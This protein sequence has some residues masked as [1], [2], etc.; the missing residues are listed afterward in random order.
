MRIMCILSL[1]IVTLLTQAQQAKASGIRDLDILF[2]IDNS[3]S[4]EQTQAKVSNFAPT[5]EK[6]LTEKNYDVR[7]AVTTTDAFYGNQ[8]LNE[9][10]SLC[11]VQQTKFRN[12]FIVGTSG[13]G[14]E[15]AFSSLEA[16]LSSPLN[17]GFHRPGAFLSVVIISDGD[18]FSH[19]TIN[20]DEDYS[21][22]TLHPISKTID[23]LNG[24]THGLPKKDYSVSTI[25]VLDSNCR[26]QLKT[27]N[28]VS[29]RY[30][31]LADLS[32]GQKTSIC[33]SIETALSKI[34]RAIQN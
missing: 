16:A 6:V 33:G 24:F 32:G 10:C 2:V 19:D 1:M 22:P 21:Q 3:G 23:F 20:I 9:G 11:N 13:S 4:M 15:R 34:S 26:D 5:F 29:V 30:M 7:M 28:K 14:D 12:D 27:E 31:E 17:V 25:S 18:D 8:F